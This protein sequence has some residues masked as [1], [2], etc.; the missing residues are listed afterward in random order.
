MR[1]RETAQAGGP[2][3]R[4]S[5]AAESGMERDVATHHLLTL[6]VDPG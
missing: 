1:V 5:G 2:G 3:A 4:E 6:A